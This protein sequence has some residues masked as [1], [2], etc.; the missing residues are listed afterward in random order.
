MIVVVGG[1]IGSGKTTVAE[2]FAEH[3]GFT[4]VYAGGMF[5]QMA[6]ARGV[7]LAAFSKEA[8]RDHSID[9]ELDGR[10]LEEVLRHDSFG[11]DVVVDGRIQA[12]LL[13]QRRVPCFKVWI[14]APLDVRVERIAGRER[15]ALEV[16]RREIL[17][18]ERSERVR[19]KEIYGIHL[20]DTSDFDL[21]IESSDKSPEQIADLILSRVRE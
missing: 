20:D 10:V 11:S 1:T 9:R 17:D 16:A 8:E 7:D 4:L 3:F 2:R 19:Y 5:R 18:R 6:A 21:R 12:H 15:K 13:A 14:D